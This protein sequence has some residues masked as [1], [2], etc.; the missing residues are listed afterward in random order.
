MWIVLFYCQ[1][2]QVIL[3]VKEH[4]K[5]ETVKNDNGGFGVSI[6]ELLKSVFSLSFL[7]MWLTEAMCEG[8]VK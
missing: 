4:K 1:F 3:N 8:I 6:F 5:R 7:D 2:F